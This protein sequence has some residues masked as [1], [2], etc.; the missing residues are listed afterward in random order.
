MEFIG[1]YGEPDG[2]PY[3][4]GDSSTGV[5][6]SY[7]NYHA[8]VDPMQE[9]LH[10][11]EQAALTP[12]GGD[13]TQLYQAIEALIATGIAAGQVPVGAVMGFD[14][15]AP[16]TGWIVGDGSAILRSSFTALDAV[17]YVGDGSNGTADAWYRCTNPANPT[18]TR[19]TTGA[20]LVTR[21]LRGVF[22]RFLDGGR[23]ID[24]GRVLGSL[25]KG[26]VHSFEAGSAVSVTG[27]RT[28]A[29]AAG[30][31][32]HPDLGLDYD[33]AI[34]TTY[35]NARQTNTNSSVI[36]GAVANTAEVGAG[37]VRPVN[38]SF[39]GCIKY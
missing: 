18:G 30:G 8:I 17:K 35:P 2:S 12:D 6:G 15:D 39:L 4:Q 10:V 21:D 37:V 13:L 16:P 11:I 32:G 3:V 36:E 24:A 25:Q 29:T 1:P 33:A 19:S 28:A 27:D 7:L 38:I 26:T 20:Y 14:L 9:I 5:K 31:V 23:G 22:S 34:A